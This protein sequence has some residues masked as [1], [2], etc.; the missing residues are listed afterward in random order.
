MPT[1][2]IPRPANIPDGKFP[3][4]WV[5]L[6]TLAF[7]DNWTTSPVAEFNGPS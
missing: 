4:H 1:S 7:L 3:E 2:T 5:D 6:I